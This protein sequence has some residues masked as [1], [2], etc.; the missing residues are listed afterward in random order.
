MKIFLFAALAVF[1]FACS[2]KENGF[3]IKV[4]LDGALGKVV[5]AENVGGNLVGVDTADFVKGAATLKGSVEYPHEYY[6]S[7]DR[8]RSN[9]VIFVENTKMEVLGNIDSLNLIKVSGSITH[10]EYQELIDQ[11]NNVQ[12]EYLSVY[13]DARDAFAAGDSV[14]GQGLLE[15]VQDMYESIDDIQA[16]FVKDHPSSYLSPVVLLEIQNNIDFEVL[17]A[18][19]NGLDPKILEIPS[20]AELKERVELLGKIAV[21][22]IAPDFTQNDPN[23][24]PVKFS[25]IY[26]QNEVT[27]LDFWAS[28]CQP[29]R[30][31]NPNVVA[32]YND[33]KDKGFTVFGVSL[34]LEKDSWLKAIQDDKLHWTQ[35]SDLAYWNNVV[36]NE[37]GINSIPSSLL[38]DKTGKI[39]AR[40][41][42]GDELRE[43]VS[44]ILD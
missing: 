39:I 19:V 24:N 16:D 36:A 14:K 32:V 37:Y 41:K 29:C 21:G 10:D 2:E 20:M 7:L 3:T 18:L 1:L 35:V 8:G 5:L 13:Q 28:W 34:D 12:L 11:I 23:G 40:D 9:A 42:R 27:L 22:Q 15:K 17:E 38:V 25:E 26:S 43:M 31:E 4:K 6:L 44:E 33:Y 30:A